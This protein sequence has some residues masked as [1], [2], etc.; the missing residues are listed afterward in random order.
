MSGKFF[1]DSNILV[2]GQDARQP[3]KQRVAQALIAQ[4]VEADSG[5]I[6]TQVL[7][8]VY[9]TVTGKVGVAPLAAK[10]VLKSFTA[11]EI[12]QVTPELVEVAVDCSILNRIS[13]WDSLI[14]AAAESA[15]CTTLYSEDLNPG[16]VV[17]G[18][19]VVNPFAHEGKTP[20]A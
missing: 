3:E 12:V 11:F 17:L 6:S 8:E 20:P 9:V 18:V 10:V 13:F 15:G 1:L 16:Q 2:Y 14:I 19:T 4:V 7:Q 5:V